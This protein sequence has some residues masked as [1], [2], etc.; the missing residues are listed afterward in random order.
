MYIIG[1][2]ASKTVAEDLSKNIDTT[3][4]R[5]IIKRFP[6]NE[7]YVCISDDIF[8]EDVIIVQTTY[9]DQNIVEMFLLQDAV[10]QAGAK[11]ITVVIPYFGYG[12]QD[13]KFKKGE[14][15]SAKAIAK[16]TRRSGRRRGSLVV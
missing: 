5:T 3:L 1:G 11:R 16:L 15:I 2:T 13:K 4:A 6:D 8:G 12:R 10:N 14:P 7:L 9:P